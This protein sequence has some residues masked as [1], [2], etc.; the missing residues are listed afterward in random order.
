MPDAAD[1]ARAEQVLARNPLVDGHNDLPWEARV[2]ASYDWAGLGFAGGTGRRTHTD[3]PRLRS[4]R[5]GAQWWSVYVP[6]SLRGQDAVAATLEQIAAVHDLVRLHPDELALVT[7]AGEV[8]AAFAE[9]RIG[10][11]LGAEGGHCID[12]SLE[13]LRELFRRGVRYLT[14]TH[15][16]NVAWADSATD[17]PRLGGLSAFG[18]EVVAD[19]NR[20][21]MLVDLSHVSAGTMHDA[22]SASR[23]P[24]IFSHS[25]ARA[26]CDHPRNVPDDVLARVAG[27]GGVVMA[28]FVPAFV[29]QEFAE[30]EAEMSAC[31][32]AQ[33]VDTDDPAA[34]D[35]FEAAYVVANPPPIVTATDV[36]AHLEHVRDV[37]GIDHV[38]IG[39]DF[40]GTTMLPVDLPDVGAFP[41]LIALLAERGWSDEDLA[42]TAG[43]NVLRVMRAA[44]DVARG[45]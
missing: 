24:V 28:T 17:E 1:R 18:R 29:S 19:M 42:R 5:V 15:G 25:N 6:T 40:D 27:N 14:L 2:Q 26:L 20:L 43:G 21:G 37:C 39:S 9:G 34:E 16:R 30:Y 41:H 32:T 31:A 3:L 4:G 35:A 45:N 36:V 23:S 7:T 38:G 33:G 13:T 8:E 22:L 11:L 44:E 10:C 12:G